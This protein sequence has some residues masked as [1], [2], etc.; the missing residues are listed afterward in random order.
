MMEPQIRPNLLLMVRTNVPI[1]ITL[2]RM[3][4]ALLINGRA[5]A[6]TTAVAPAA[7]VTTLLQDITTGIPVQVVKLVQT[8]S[9]TVLQHLNSVT[10]EQLT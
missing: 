1:R 5:R 10:T 7:L 2:Q 6:V 3:L 9:T 8:H 4:R